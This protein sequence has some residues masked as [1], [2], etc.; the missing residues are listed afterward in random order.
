MIE[1]LASRP[2]PDAERHR[3]DAPRHC[4]RCAA[5]LAGADGVS[6][7][8]VEYW[9]VDDRVFHCWCAA[10]GWVGDIVPTTRMVGHEPEH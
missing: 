2:D 3:R 1:P 10:C 4:P 7:L 5:A 9:A 8:T 6:G